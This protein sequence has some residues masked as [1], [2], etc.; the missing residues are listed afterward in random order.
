[1]SPPT[2]SN[3]NAANGT[4][5]GI[6]AQATDNDATTNTVTYSLFDDAGGRFTI[7]ANSGIVT[8]ADGTL[9]NREAA[10]SH[11]ITVRAT[12]ADGST[13]DTVFTISVTDINEAPEITSNGGGATAGVSLLEN[14]TAV[15]TITASDV[16]IGDTL[17]YGISGGADAGFFSIDAGSGVLTFDAAPDFETRVDANGDG[18]YEV[19]VRASDALATADDQALGVQVLDQSFSVPADQVFTSP[20]LASD[21]QLLG[22]L[23]TSGDRPTSFVI[24]GGDSAGAFAVDA[25][26]RLS[27]A[28]VFLL[29]GGSNSYQLQVDVSDG[30]TTVRQTVTVTTERTIAVD[31]VEPPDGGP[32]VIPPTVIDPPSVLDDVDEIEQESIPLTPTLTTATDPSGGGDGQE[33]IVDTVVFDVDD[34]VIASD[35][36]DT[37]SGGQRT[38]YRITEP[39]PLF[40]RMVAAKLLISSGVLDLGTGPTAPLPFDPADDEA[41]WAS[42][43]IVMADLDAAGDGADDDMSLFLETAGAAALSLTVGFVVWVLRTGALAASLMSISPLWRQIDPLPVLREDEEDTDDDWA[44]GL[45]DDDDGFTIS[46]PD[47]TPEKR[48][49]RNQ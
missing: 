6:T 12:S 30:T 38:A 5:V 25:L 23:Q 21:G 47:G 24:T 49:G 11:D 43:D 41:L 4:A 33:Q 35:V 37:D 40:A 14:G 19:V 10:A 28:D 46:D 48:T 2:R 32:S 16:D 29:S 27:I 7:D 17:T 9:L 42:L 8:V 1:M 13:A 34:L 3:E 22:Q 36:A 45:N 15:T 31:P 39:V 20:E 26:G 44:F 18:V